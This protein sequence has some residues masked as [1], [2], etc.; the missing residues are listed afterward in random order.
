MSAAAEP[1]FWI[2]F[3]VH[4]ATT[5]DEAGC[6]SCGTVSTRTHSSY[7]RRLDDCAA[8][9]RRVVVELRVR[10]FRCRERACPRTTFVEQAPG[11]PS[12]TGGGARA[13]RPRCSSSPWP[14]PAGPA[15]VRSRPSW[16]P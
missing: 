12:V 5:G 2:T 11:L 9:R 16:S 3:P 4:A 15:P 14:W 13:C 8:G 10:R 1:W 6:P 7:V